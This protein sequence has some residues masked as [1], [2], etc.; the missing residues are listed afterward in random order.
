MKKLFY[1]L[2]VSIAASL[3]ITSCT[4]EDVAPSLESSGSG[5]GSM[6]DDLK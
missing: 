4:E 3:A 2:I 1:I 6:N 5:G